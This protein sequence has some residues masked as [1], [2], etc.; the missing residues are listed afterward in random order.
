MTEFE[1]REK[2]YAELRAGL[3]D[4]ADES[5]IE[6][7]E[8]IAAEVISGMG[9]SLILKMAAVRRWPETELWLRHEMAN[10]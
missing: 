8:E 10:L 6:D 7:H 1:I 5:Y 4:T 2:I 9:L 3:S